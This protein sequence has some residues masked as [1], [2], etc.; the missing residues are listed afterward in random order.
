MID[1]CISTEFVEFHLTAGEVQ[2]WSYVQYSL[3]TSFESWNETNRIF[4]TN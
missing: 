3:H 2:F 1:I 4:T